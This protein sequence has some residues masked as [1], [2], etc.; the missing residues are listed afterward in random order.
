MSLSAPWLVHIATTEDNSSYVINKATDIRGKKKFT[1]RRR[2]LTNHRKS[3]LYNSLGRLESDQETER[4]NDGWIQM[5]S[6][7]FFLTRVLQITGT[8]AFLSSGGGSVM[9]CSFW[10]CN[11]TV[12]VLGSQQLYLDHSPSL[13]GMELRST[14]LVQMW[15]MTTVAAPPGSS[16]LSY[17]P[18]R[19][20]NMGRFTTTSVQAAGWVS[21]RSVLWL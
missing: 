21:Q 4:K 16:V 6:Y 8:D 2:Q 20:S 19:F 7:F 3:T 14:W 13:S 10:L 17:T 18:L 15:R 12:S 1:M 11:C 9:Q 5:D